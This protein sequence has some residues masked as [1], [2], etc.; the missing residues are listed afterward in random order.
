MIFASIL[1]SRRE[2]HCK[3]QGGLTWL[4]EVSVPL[5]VV[6]FIIVYW[7]AGM[8]ISQ[9]YTVFHLFLCLGL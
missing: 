4:G 5:L 8:N 2:I 1:S 9:G 6:H 3:L 7:G